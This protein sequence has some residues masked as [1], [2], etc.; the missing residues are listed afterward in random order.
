MRFFT[1][2]LHFGHRKVAELRGHDDFV[3]HDRF[4]REVWRSQVTDD[5]IVYVL[6]DISLNGNH[7]LNCLRDLPGRKRLIAGNHD[8]VHP[9]FSKAANAMPKWLEV[10]ETIASAGTVKIGGRRVLL[11]HYP[12]TGDSGPVD[13]DRQWRLPNHGELLLHGHTHSDKAYT[14]GLELHVGWDTWRAL[15]TEEVVDFMLRTY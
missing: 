7:G 6:G 15:V 11:S 14:S 5:D 9:K 13:R 12:Y 1:S 8:A 3:D 4:I 2:D 10:F